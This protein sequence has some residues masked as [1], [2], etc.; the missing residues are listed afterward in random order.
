MKFSKSSQEPEMIN[1]FRKGRSRI[2]KAIIKVKVK[3]IFDK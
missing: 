3:E 1:Y 2:D